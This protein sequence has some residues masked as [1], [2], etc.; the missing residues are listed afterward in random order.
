MSLKTWIFI[1]NLHAKRKWLASHTP[2]TAFCSHQLGSYVGSTA[3]FEMPGKK[4]IL[5]VLEIEYV[6]SNSTASQ[7]PKTITDKI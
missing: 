1:L 2:W 7:L 3:G 4:K 6:S 5:T